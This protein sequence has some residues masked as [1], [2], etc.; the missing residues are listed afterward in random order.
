[1]FKDKSIL[2]IGGTGTIGQALVN[3]LISQSPKVI[4]ILSRDEYKQYQMQQK[5]E[6]LEIYVSCW[7]MSGIRNVFTKQ[8][9][10]LTLFLTW[11]H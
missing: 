3:K 9:I 10:G 5:L 7:G 11:L 2:V 8:C 6:G 1:M 4:R